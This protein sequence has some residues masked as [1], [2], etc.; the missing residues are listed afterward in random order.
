MG[1]QRESRYIIT[2]SKSFDMNKFLR[3][4]CSIFIMPVKILRKLEDAKIFFLSHVSIY[5]TFRC[6][7]ILIVHGAAHNIL[8]F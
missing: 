7:N 8:L 4:K 5:S 1:H 6:P 2:S 3:E